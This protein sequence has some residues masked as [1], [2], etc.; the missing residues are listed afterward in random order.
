MSSL[1]GRAHPPGLGH[2]RQVVTTPPDQHRWLTALFPP[3][4][5]AADVM[6]VWRGE[7][8]GMRSALPDGCT[9]IVWIE[10]GEL[11]F[12]G[13]ATKVMRFWRP[14]G[15]A[16][17]GVAFRP[18]AVTRILGPDVLARSSADSFHPLVDVV[19]H[20][21]LETVQAAISTAADPLA[22]LVDGVR[23]LVAAATPRT[24]DERMLTEGLTATHV[25]PVTELAA[26][27]AMSVRQLHRVGVAAYGFAP[28]TLARIVRLQR[29]LRLGKAR[30]E[31]SIADLAAR[32]GYYDHSHLCR[33]ARTIARMSPTEVL[34]TFDDA[35]PA[36]HDPYLVPGST[37]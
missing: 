10:P 35:L 17:V 30:G 28:T 15:R 11:W 5:L 13:P 37:T 18:G 34:A 4:D 24:T 19:D 31:L 22:G 23:P 32:A 2:D 29:F 6:T 3:V 1:S 20:G 16:I 12:C 21:T 8:G 26:R 25:P 9:G 14:S 36:G 33:E 7:C 27:L